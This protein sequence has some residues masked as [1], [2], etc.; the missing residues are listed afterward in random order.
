MTLADFCEYCQSLPGVEGSTP[1]GPQVLVY[2]VGGKMFALAVPDELLQQVNERV[3]L[4]CE[5]ERA[6]ELRDRHEDIVPGYHMNKRHW[7]TLTLPGKL[8]TKLVRELTDHSYALVVAS[9]PRKLR[10]SLP[11]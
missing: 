4:K 11:A 7:N 9:L 5:P 8:P 1:F 6:V 3:N 2:K 10:E